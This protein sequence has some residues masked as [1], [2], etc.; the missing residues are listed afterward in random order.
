MLFPGVLVDVIEFFQVGEGGLKGIGGGLDGSAFLFAFVVGDAINE[1][2]VLVGFAALLA[3]IGDHIVLP[4]DGI[5]FFE[6]GEII[7]GAD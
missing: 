4:E 7:L 1:A 3:P 2:A 6:A 5:V